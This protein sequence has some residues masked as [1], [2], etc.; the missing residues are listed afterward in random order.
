MDRCCSKEVSGR[1]KVSE[2]KQGLHELLK[3][4]EG[5]LIIVSLLLL[6][7]LSFAVLSLQGSEK[8][9]VS[10]GATGEVIIQLVDTFRNEF[11]KKILRKSQKCR[12][13]F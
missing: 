13:Q 12:D 1:P 2:V 6:S 9:P 11:D 4:T 7:F 10:F 8:R 5:T 3:H